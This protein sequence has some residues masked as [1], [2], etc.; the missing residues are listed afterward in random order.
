[1][2]YRMD[3]PVPTP[4]YRI[5]HVDNLET[6]LRR[7]A[8]CA[9]NHAPADRLPYRTIHNA[10]IQNVRRVRTIPCG[11]GGVVHDYVA[12]YFG[13]LSPML[14]QLK[15]GRVSGYNE[16][17]EPIIYLMSTVETVAEAEAEFVFSDGHGIAAYTQWFDR[18]QSL[19]RVDWDMVYQ[20]YWADTLEDMDRQR[21]K[22]AEFLVHRRC[23]W[24]LIQEIGVLNGA[25]KARVE[26]VLCQFAPAIHRPVSIRQEWYY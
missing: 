19:D 26:S 18:V 25:A 24:E 10:D 16:G 22:Q 17:Q 13:Y 14:F 2:E 7:G 6:C 12:F 4:I 9:P 1:M 20:R 8:L 23:D 5:I 11:P 3:I 21:R 15:T